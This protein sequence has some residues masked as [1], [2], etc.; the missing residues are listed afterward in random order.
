MSPLRPGCGGAA[1][2]RQRITMTQRRFHP[3][4][5]NPRALRDALGRFATGVCVITATAPQGPCAITANSFA[6]VSL[7]PPLVL[8]S[9]DRGS[10]RY[11]VFAGAR[12]SA[13]HV[14]AQA[15]VALARRFARDGYDFSGLALETGPEGLPLLTGCAC[16]LL[17][18][19][20]ATHRGGDHDILVLRVLEVTT[21]PV[22][23]LLFADGRFGGMA[24]DGV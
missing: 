2:Q 14:L 24:P 16:R 23:P 1:R 15:Q 22:A 13:V 17:C 4:A 8:W 7:D 20:E 9:V 19:T 6:S 18:H 12:H 10:V 11:P 5:D 21:E 3:S